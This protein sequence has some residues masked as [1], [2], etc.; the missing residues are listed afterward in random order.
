MEACATVGHRSVL[1]L[2]RRTSKTA[3]KLLA[4]AVVIIWNIN[5]VLVAVR[6]FPEISWKEKI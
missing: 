5:F 4:G 6:Y 1:K 2:A 3:K